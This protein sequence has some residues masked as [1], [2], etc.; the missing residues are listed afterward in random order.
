MEKIYGVPEIVSTE[1]H[2]WKVVD[3]IV[4]KTNLETHVVEI[5][6]LGGL[7]SSRVRMHEFGHVRF[8][9]GNL[10]KL[11]NSAENAFNQ[12]LEEIRVDVLMAEAGINTTGR[13]KGN[14]YK[15]A[16]LFDRLATY[17]WACAVEAVALWKDDPKLAKRYLGYTGEHAAVVEGAAEWMSSN[18][19]VDT[20]IRLAKYL[21]SLYPEA[22]SIL[23]MCVIPASGE[24]GGD[25]EVIRIPTELEGKVFGAGGV[26]EGLTGVNKRSF[27]LE[28]LKIC[29][30]IDLE[31][32]SR[33]VRVTK[34]SRDRGMEPVLWDR[35]SDKNIFQRRRRAGAI[36]I[37]VSGSMGWD[38]GKLE[39]LVE[40][41]PAA[42][43]A[44]YSGVLDTYCCSMPSTHKHGQLCIIAKDGKWAPP[45]P[46]HGLQRG[47]NSVDIDGL[48]WLSMQKGPRVWLSD[49]GV[50]S[51][52]YN[53]IHN[54]CCKLMK[55]GNVVRIEEVSE[56]V[57]Y[58]DRRVAS[59]GYSVHDEMKRTRWN[60][61]G[62]EKVKWDVLER[63]L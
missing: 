50:T 18:P 6:K 57:K 20:R 16:S 8:S 51:A 41:V 59:V 29:D 17:P 9:S 40:K 63:C 60:G 48:M 38:W 56:A 13:G 5:P 45:I 23:G 28:F 39:A 1:K 47:A 15:D 30:H 54:V 58:M 62:M 27:K 43:I 2:E 34:G 26:P 12:A 36:L 14:I 37:D 52:H 21:A 19:E 11:D 53:D 24:S 55:V 4:G 42:T 31:L 33:T 25:E 10:Q 46:N 32:S 35:W 44:T 49:G 3:S 22:S 61:K 7:R